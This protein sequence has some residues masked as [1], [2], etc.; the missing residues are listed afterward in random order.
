MTVVSPEILVEA[1]Q[2]QCKLPLLILTRPM[3]MLSEPVF[4]LS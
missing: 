2:H 4:G 1:A 3:P